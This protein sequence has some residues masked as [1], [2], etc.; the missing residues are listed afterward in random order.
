[1]FVVIIPA[2]KPDGTLTE[3]IDKLES[4]DVEKIV[5]DD[6]SGSEYEDIFRTVEDR[7]ILLRHEKN[8]GKGAAVKTGLSEVKEMREQIEA[9]GIMDSDGQHLP[10]DMMK[11]L[12]AASVNKEALIL[13]VRQVG[14]KMPLRS[15]IG[16]TVTRGVFRLV[17][18]TGVSDTQTGLRAFSPELTDRLLQIEGERY[19]YEMNM[20]MTFARED[21]PVREVPVSTVYLDRKNSVSHFRT[22][23]DSARIYKDII[24]FSLSSL[25][26]FVLDYV[27]FALLMMLLPHTAGWILTANIAARLV[28]AMYNYS[29]NCRFV[30]REKKRAS[31]ALEYFALA[32]FILI[33]NNLLLELFTQIMGI[34]VYPAKLLTECTLFVI[35][36]L[37]Q[38]F[39]IFKRNRSVR[40]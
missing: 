35:S 14:R 27:L 39:M 10:E 40:A 22:V 18:G 34:P 11:L 9:V 20:L 37:V 23:A 15:R 30:F 36:W 7:C 33:M 2:Y 12:A 28:S 5:V 6:G 31:T 17:T 8:R 13:G 3:L 21:T 26:S 1:M 32:G 38:N 16:N 25:S 24:R 4:F 29:V 19:E